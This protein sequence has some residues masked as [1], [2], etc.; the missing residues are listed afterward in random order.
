MSIKVTCS[1]CYNDFNITPSRLIGKSNFFCCKNC[2]SNFRKTI[3]IPNTTCPTCKKEFYVKTFRL[4]RSKNVCCSRECSNKLREITF[5]GENNHQYGLNGELNSSYKSDLM[6]SKYGYIRIRN[7]QHPFKNYDDFIFLHRS[8]M[9]EYLK[10]TQPDSEYL[11]SVAGYNDK[12]L[13]PDVIVHHKNENKIDNR[14]SNLEITTLSEH[15]SMHINECIFIRNINGT[16][17]NIIGKKK[18][19]KN[20]NNNLCKDNLYDAGLDIRSC[21]NIKIQAKCSSLISTDLYISIPENHVGLIWSRS[22]LS[23]KH[24]IEVGAGCIDATYRGEV[25]VHLYNHSDVD[26]DVNIGD[27]IAQLLTIP[28][29][30]NNYIEVEELEE[31][32]RGEGGFGSTGIN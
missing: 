23:V 3:K 31:T 28:I 25:K 6:I 26:Y 4:K 22:G 17:L 19:T 30:I 2:E 24:K 18:K 5:L 29:N 13:T 8:I 14:I 11:I 27:K 10:L 32:V 16:F 9:E 15:S 21:E 12:Y 7:T 20:S 1:N